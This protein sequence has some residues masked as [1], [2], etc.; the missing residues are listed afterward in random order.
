MQ[1]R[2]TKDLPRW[3]MT[4]IARSRAREITELPA[5]TAEAAIT[6]VIREHGI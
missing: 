4:V 1:R 6:R 2:S 5:E 3:R